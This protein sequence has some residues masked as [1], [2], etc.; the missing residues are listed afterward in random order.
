MTRHSGPDSP[1]WQ[2]GR[3]CA[4]VIAR[5]SRA[6]QMMWWYSCSDFVSRVLS[7]FRSLLAFTSFFE[8]RIDRPNTWKKDADSA[9]LPGRVRVGKLVR[10]ARRPKIFSSIWD[11]AI[12]G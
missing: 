2:Y 10:L 6:S 5:P 7:S 4:S 1:F 9:S 11:T 8:S 3:M 12:D